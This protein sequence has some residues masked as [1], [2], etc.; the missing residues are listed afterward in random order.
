MCG[1]KVFY[2]ENPSVTALSDSNVDEKINSFVLFI[3]HDI[4]HLVD[5]K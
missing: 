5:G 2:A 4:L 1:K 3:T